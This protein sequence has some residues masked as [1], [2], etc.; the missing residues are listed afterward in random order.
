MDYSDSQLST[1]SLKNEF[2]ALNTSYVPGLSSLL[3]EFG[4]NKLTC[5][6]TEEDF[7]I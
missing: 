6:H 1:G 3:P 7:H 4:P 5:S 2:G